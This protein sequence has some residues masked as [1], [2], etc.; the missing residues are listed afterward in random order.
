MNCVEAVL[1]VALTH[2]NFAI[3]LGFVYTNGIYQ[4]IFLEV[5]SR[6][7]T[8]TSWVSSG[9]LGMLSFA[10]KISFSFRLIHCSLFCCFRVLRC[11]IDRY[12]K[13][14]ILQTHVCVLHTFIY[15]KW[16]LTGLILLL[17]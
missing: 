11:L 17:I 9:Q 1:L 4:I 12:I 3:I 15:K 13:L 6:G 5:F 8:V 16:C 2:I 7:S 10:G 14:G